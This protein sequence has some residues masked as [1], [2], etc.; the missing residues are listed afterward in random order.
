[1]CSKGRIQV[2]LE[3]GWWGQLA[4][5]APAPGEGAPSSLSVAHAPQARQGKKEAPWYIISTDPAI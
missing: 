2:K 3:D 4:D 1:M 5:L